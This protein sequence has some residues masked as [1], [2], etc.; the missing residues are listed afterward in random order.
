MIVTAS[1]LLPLIL[2][3]A[4]CG[5]APGGHPNHKQGEDAAVTRLNGPIDGQPIMDA[6]E[7]HGPIDTLP[8]APWKQVGDLRL[9]NCQLGAWPFY[10]DVSTGR[11]FDHEGVEFERLE[12][13][14]FG[15]INGAKNIFTGKVHWNAVVTINLGQALAKEKDGAIAFDVPAEADHDEESEAKAK[16]AAPKEEARWGLPKGTVYDEG[17]YLLGFDGRPEWSLEVLHGPLKSVKRTGSFKVDK[18]TAYAADE[19]D[20]RGS[21]FDIG[22]LT[23]S[24]DAQSLMTETDIYANATPQVPGFNRGLWAA[25]ERQSRENVA[26]GSTAWVV[27]LPIYSAHPKTI[28]PHKVQIPADYAKSE[29]IVKGGKPVKIVSWEAPNKE[30]PAGSKPEQFVVPLKQVEKDSGLE[31]WKLAPEGLK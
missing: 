20:Y 14:S 24:E 2:L 4:L 29:L 9:V 6:S 13:H 7:W 26:D 11:M 12:P 25:I 28:G 16:A 15:C 23:A 8:V 21:G 17:E 18:Q 3:L 1:R 19:A 22:H 30:P 5:C 27:T 10:E 31:L